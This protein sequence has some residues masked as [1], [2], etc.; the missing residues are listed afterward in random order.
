MT[1]IF[2]DARSTSPVGAAAAQDYRLAAERRG[3]T[4]VPVALS[5]GL[6][7]NLRRVALRRAAGAAAGSRTTTTKLTDLALV[8][9]VR[10]EEVMYR[11]GGG[12]GA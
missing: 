3:V 7:E 10:Q 5:C 2:T 4:F 1:W 11:F 6:E 12:G 8:Q 9:Q